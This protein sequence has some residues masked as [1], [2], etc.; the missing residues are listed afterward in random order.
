MFEKIISK[1]KKG[2]GAVTAMAL[3]VISNPFSLVALATDDKKT[4]TTG[5]GDIVNNI[6]NQPVG[7]SG[8]DI[9]NLNGKIQTTGGQFYKLIISIGL[10][11]FIIAGA[12][13]MFK[14]FFAASPQEKQEAK[15]NMLI[16]VIAVVGFFAVPALIGLLAGVGNTLLGTTK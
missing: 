6:Q 10:V 16:K 1:V 4:D 12:W 3:M 8:S 11:G 9:A 14:M 7:T 2:L 13:A 5:V 15:S